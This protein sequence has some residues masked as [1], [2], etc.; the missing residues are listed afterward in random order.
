[1]K[2]I[3]ELSVGNTFTM[4]DGLF[5]LTTDFKGNGD[6]Y[7]ICLSD[8]TVRWLPSNAVVE[9]CPIYTLDKDNNILPVQLM[10]KNAQN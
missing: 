6:K 7:C 8:G 10:P 4:N 9:V 2:Y 5:I 3:E 1:M